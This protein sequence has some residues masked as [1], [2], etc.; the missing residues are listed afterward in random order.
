MQDID[1]KEKQE[2]RGQKVEAPPPKLL[3][4]INKAAEALS[5]SRAYMYRLVM[6]GQVKS[7]K[8]G[9]S[10][11]IKYSALQEFVDRLMERGE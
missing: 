1:Q 4:T 10:R 3:Y 5:L 11:R 9:G 7:V 2:Q 8:I 6:A